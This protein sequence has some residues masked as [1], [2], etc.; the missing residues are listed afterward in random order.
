M[1]IIIKED[2]KVEME[3]ME[4]IIKEAK[5][6]KTQDEAVKRQKAEMKSKFKFV[7]VGDVKSVDLKKA[8]IDKNVHFGFLKIFKNSGVAIVL[9]QEEGTEVKEKIGGISLGGNKLEFEELELGEKRTR[10]SPPSPKKSKETRSPRKA[11]KELK[12]KEMKSKFKFRNLGRVKV[13]ALKE[14]LRD[15]KVEP[16]FVVVYMKFGV[17]IV[18]FKEMSKEMA[19]KLK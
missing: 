14:I 16:G 8:L 13:S 9:F 11:S 4:I 6:S 7:N 18:M 10:S 1:E 19:M 2:K 5:E 15:C 12:L 17:A 3:E